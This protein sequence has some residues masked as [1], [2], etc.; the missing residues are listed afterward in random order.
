MKVYFSKNVRY[1]KQTS[2]FEFVGTCFLMILICS[3]QIK[4]LK[5]NNFF[6]KL[7]DFIHVALNFNNF[8]K[9]CMEISAEENY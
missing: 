8:L 5:L 1:Q 7:A 2:I 4:I 3:F 9:R 6:L